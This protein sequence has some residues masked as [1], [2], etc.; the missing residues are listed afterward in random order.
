MKIRIFQQ[1]TH[2]GVTYPAGSEPDLPED[3]ARWLLTQGAEL[4][5]EAVAAAE[6][7]DKVFGD[8]KAAVEAR[9]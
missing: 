2:A 9:K 7:V 4:R 5:A 8:L 6:R 3:V 1:H